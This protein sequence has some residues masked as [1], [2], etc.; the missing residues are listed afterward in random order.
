MPH[1]RLR[2]ILEDFAEKNAGY[3]PP[4]ETPKP[5][6]LMQHDQAPPEETREEISA[7]TSGG[8]TKKRIEILHSHH[9]GIRQGLEELI[10]K[11]QEHEKL[12]NLSKSLEKEISETRSDIAQHAQ[13]IVNHLKHL[14]TPFSHESH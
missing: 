12:S 2:D 13:Q 14:K 3:D 8:D 4:P 5:E 7:E 11:M 1:K 6:E 10:P 9:E